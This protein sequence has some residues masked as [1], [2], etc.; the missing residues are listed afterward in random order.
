MLFRI[1]AF[2]LSIILT[3]A[4]T[5]AQT[6]AE[7]PRNDYPFQCGAAYAIL[8]ETFRL[9]D[10]LQESERY[11][12]KF[13]TLAGNAEEAFLRIGRSKEDAQAYMQRHVDDL[14]ALAARGDAHLVIG[15]AKRCDS[16]F[17]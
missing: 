15:F 7:G 5:V 3:P 11:R 9:T 13:T 6:G 1:A 14:A 17:P 8:A 10:K 4:M 2:L 12:M 16:L